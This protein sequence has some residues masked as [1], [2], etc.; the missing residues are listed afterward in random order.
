MI[1]LILPWPPS[2]NHY[3]RIGRTVITAK[4]KTFQ[5]R[6]NTD[7]TNRFY[8]EAW[9]RIR[10][11]KAVNRKETPLHSTISLTMYAY[12]P[13][14]RKR[15][16]DNIIKPAVDSLVRGGLLQDDSQISRLLIERRGIIKQGKV[17]MIIEEIL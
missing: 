6:V 15:D 3:K 8:Y 1:E 10:S 7:E 11:W 5:S 17:I 9:L 2:V 13:D 16:V 14:Q 12:P 4:G